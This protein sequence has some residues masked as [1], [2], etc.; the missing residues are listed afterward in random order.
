MPNAGDEL[1]HMG[2]NSCSSCFNDPTKSR[3]KLILPG[4]ASSRIHVVD[5]SSERAPKLHKV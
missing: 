4:I 5:T 3:N 1:H 2:W